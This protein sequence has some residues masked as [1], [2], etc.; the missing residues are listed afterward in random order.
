MASCADSDEEKSHVQVVASCDNEGVT[1]I[2]EDAS[3]SMALEEG[4]VEVAYINI[5]EA[6]MLD[7]IEGIET[8]TM[9]DDT[10]R[11]SWEFGALEIEEDI[12]LSEEEAVTVNERD[13]EEQI[14]VTNA[15]LAGK[16]SFQD[17]ITRVEGPKNPEETSDIEENDDNNMSTEED[18]EYIPPPPEP[19]EKKS[20]G[21]SL[22]GK[23]VIVESAIIPS[24]GEI[25]K[26]S[27]SPQKKVKKTR[28]LGP[29]INK[30]LPANL[31]GIVLLILI[32]K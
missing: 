5:S 27:K 23:P 3:T 15:Y 25:P 1:V 17:F 9:D 22:K 6:M 19:K 31:L 21:K 26:S 16:I 29:K 32:I 7:E 2:N 12:A 8:S 20:K 13:D 28:K 14:A 24:S 11:Q 10:T 18:P 4:L 30:K